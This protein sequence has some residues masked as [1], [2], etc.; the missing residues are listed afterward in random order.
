MPRLRRTS[1]G[2]VLRILH[3]FGFAVSDQKGSHAKLVRVAP[4]DDRQVLIVALHRKLATGTLHAIYR[5]AVRLVP[6]VELRRAFF[7]G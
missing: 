3:R 4:G 7:T 6:S 5:K 1:S 2:D